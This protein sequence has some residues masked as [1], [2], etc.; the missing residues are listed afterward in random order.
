MKGS[1]YNLGMSLMY[2]RLAYQSMS[3]DQEEA[4]LAVDRV[5]REEAALEGRLRALAEIIIKKLEP[6]Q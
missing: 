4:R 1:K 6:T 2:L 5:S 3:K